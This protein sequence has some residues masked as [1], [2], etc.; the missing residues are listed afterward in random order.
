MQHSFLLQCSMFQA[1]SRRVGLC[2]TNCG[3]TTTTL[4]R[5]NNEGEPV[6]NACGLYYK[7]HGVNRPLAMRKDGI[8]TRKRK[9]KNASAASAAATAAAAAAVDRKQKTE[10]ET[11]RVHSICGQ[12]LNV[13][14]D[15]S[16]YQAV[17]EVRAHSSQQHEQQQQQQP[18]QQ[19]YQHWQQ[20]QHRC[21]Q[22]LQL[23]FR[24]RRHAR[25]DPHQAPFQCQIRAF[26]SATAA[27]PRSSPTS[28]ATATAT[29]AATAATPT[30]AA[31]LPLLPD[32]G[33][34]GGSCG[35][36]RRRRFL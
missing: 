15:T 22:S 11:Q 32:V 25:Y 6:C 35:R 24:G 33:R 27:T 28:S 36:R 9:P 16:R 10:G 4:W 21:Q 13:S 5:R 29:A 7:L 26:R 20:Q 8:Q 17:A 34:F 1:S 19:N 3:T 31:T 23:S 2:C 14:A 30:P 12:C 18:L